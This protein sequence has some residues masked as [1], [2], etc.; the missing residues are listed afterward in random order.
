MHRELLQSPV[1]YHLNLTH[2]MQ[3]GMT[4][5][6]RRTLRLVRTWRVLTYGIMLSSYFR[7]VMLVSMCLREMCIV[8]D[9]ISSNPAIISTILYFFCRLW[10]GSLCWDQCWYSFYQGTNY[11]KSAVQMHELGHNFNMAH[12]G[13]LNGQTYTDHTGAMGNPLYSDEVG[14]V[15]KHWFSILIWSTRL[16]MQVSFLSFLV[17]LDMFQC[18][19]GKC[20][21]HCIGPIWIG[22]LYQ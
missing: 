1:S 14:K 21:W 2:V 11:Y 10:L 9:H 13:G 6:V 4:A 16:L 19:K 17:L 12:S 5:L 18:C 8:H 20:L 22:Q 3:L 15:S 7:N